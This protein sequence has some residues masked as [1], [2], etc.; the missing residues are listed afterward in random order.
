MGAPIKVINAGSRTFTNY[1]YL[2][3]RLDWFFML[4]AKDDI[5]IISGCANGADRL[6]ERYATEN[7]IGLIRKPANWNEHHN[8]AGPIRNEEMAKIATHCIVFW[9]GISKGTKNMIDNANKYKLDLR[10]IKV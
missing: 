6:G 1:E 7:G 2:K 8:A 10:I 4:R 9:D 3:V 5:T